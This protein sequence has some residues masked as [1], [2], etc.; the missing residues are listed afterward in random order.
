MQ[1]LSRLDRYVGY[2]IIRIFAA[3]LVILTLI[4]VGSS[5]I[6]VLRTAA[7]GGISPDSVLTLMSL[8]LLRLA[9]RLVPVA[10][11]FATVMALGRM[12]QEQ[13]MTAL[14]SSGVSPYRLFKI[15]G[16]VALPMVIATAWLVM[17]IYPATGR[18]SEHITTQFRDQLLLSSMEG[19]RFYESNQ[20]SLVFY[21]E[22][23]DID[24]GEL[25]NVFLHQ[26]KDDGTIT[27]TVSD[28]GIHQVDEVT[29]L[30]RVI[31]KNGYQYQAIPGAMET[32]QVD[33]D[34]FIIT[35]NR[36]PQK[37]RRIRLRSVDTAELLKMPDRDARIEF[38]SRLVFPLSV[39]AF[40]FLAVPLSR[41]RVRQ[42][43]YLR[44]LLAVVVYVLFTML[45]N[46]AETWA[47]KGVTPLW[48]GVWWVPAMMILVV[49]LL[50]ALD[51][52]ASRKWWKRHV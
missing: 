6:R 24:T 26:R 4:L 32:N 8:E 7:S 51:H 29:G 42:S 10:F 27:V 52:P 49:A 48:M 50:L 38:E 33:F 23:S 46:S 35:V 15:V 9:G 25:S 43:A 47:E 19:G 39:V 20:G 31:L 12:Y 40:G 41:S 34:E 3:I 2:E 30:R 28:K 37:E 5:L 22:A 1:L 44:V 16:I 21:A 13:E 18:V 17:V 45:T 11:F 14:F 36:P